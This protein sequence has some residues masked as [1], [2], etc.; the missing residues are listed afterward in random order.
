MVAFGN[1][2][3][4]ATGPTIRFFPPQNSGAGGTFQLGPGTVADGC[5]IPG[6]LVCIVALSTWN[7]QAWYRDPAGPCG[8][9]FH[10]TNALSVTDTP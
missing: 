10:A 3:R 2:L 1:G 8:A 4:C 5:A 6:P 9:G 7:Y